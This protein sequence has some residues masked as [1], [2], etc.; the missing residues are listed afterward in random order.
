MGHKKGKQA[1]EFS[2]KRAN[3]LHRYLLNDYI[4]EADEFRNPVRTTFRAE[5]LGRWHKDGT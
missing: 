5:D 3:S 1:G 4:S 2:N